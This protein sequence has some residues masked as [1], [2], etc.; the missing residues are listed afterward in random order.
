MP[1]SMKSKDAGSNLNR[2]SFVRNAGG[3]ALLT[4]LHLKPGAFAQST[5][6][7]MDRLSDYMG[8]S[9][10]RPLPAEVLEHVKIHVLD[11]L[12]AMISGS[13]LVPGQAAIKFLL[14]SPTPGL[15]SVATSKVKYDSI[16]AAMV[17]GMLAHSDESDDSNAPSL[18]HPGCSVIPAALALGEQFNISGMHFL[19]AVAL[20]YDIGPRMTLALGAAKFQE[21]SHRS[22]HSIAG[23]FGAAAAAGCAAGLT[24]HEMRWLLDFTAQQAAGFTAW[25]RDTQHIEKAFVFAGMPA[26][27]GV[28]AALLVKSGW[29]GVD[30]VLSG[31][32]NFFLATQPNALPSALVDGLGERYLI[33]RTNIKKWP[34]GS[35]IQAALDALE[36]LIKKHQLAPDSIQDITVRMTNREGSVVNNRDMPDICLQHMLA[37]M[38]ADGKVTFK[39]THDRA[40][41]QDPAVLRQRAKI[42]LVA[43]E[44]MQG[45][46]AQRQAAVDVRLADGTQY[47]QHVAAVRGTVENPMTRDEVVGKARDLIAPVLGTNRASALIEAVFALE[48][49]KGVRTLGPMLHRI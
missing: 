9:F 41:M 25:Q 14:S 38:L 29:S 11:T 20:G 36:I 43:D 17:N 28:T 15:A 10:E 35:P 23:V 47:T 6:S 26:R 5:P 45:P 33:A 27:N 4:G 32:D 42:H 24:A 2:R 30:D 22:S 44:S 12:A 46:N 34:V 21:D 37:L 31:S 13:T 7:V 19:R 1:V 18:S 49:T 39:A 16:E 40:R 3:F 48:T 8:A